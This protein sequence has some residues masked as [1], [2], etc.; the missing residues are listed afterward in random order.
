[1]EDWQ[2]ILLHLIFWN[3]CGALLSLWSWSRQGRVGAVLGEHFSC[4][5]VTDDYAAYDTIFSKHQLCWAHFLR[6][7]V[8]L[9]LRN[10]TNASYRRFYIRLLLLYCLAKRYQH[11]Q[12]LS[13][14]R[15]AKVQ[16]LQKKILKLCKRYREE[17]ITETKAAKNDCDKSQI[18]SDSE[19][20]MIRL[21]KELVEK[22]DC[23]FVFY[24]SYLKI[25]LDE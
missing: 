6:K 3:A 24:R 20:K 21:Q 9:M 14:G 1:L 16:E 23:L 18:T 7:A 19:A 15:A 13:T 4:I 25:P 12:R 22:L 17:I 5:G 11:D 2:E 8:E 10:P